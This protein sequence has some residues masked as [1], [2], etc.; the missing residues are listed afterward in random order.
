MYK[1]IPG[2]DPS[3][4]EEYDDLDQIRI[5]LKELEPSSDNPHELAHLNREAARIIE[6][7]DPENVGI[8]LDRLS[9]TFYKDIK[10]AATWHINSERIDA[11]KLGVQH[12]LLDIASI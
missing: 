9:H 1:E 2:Y 7:I 4:F 12:T 11:F 5:R 6:D 3:D 10:T 8:Y